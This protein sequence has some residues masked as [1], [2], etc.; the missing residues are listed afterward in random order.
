MQRRSRSAKP[1]KDGREQ[2]ELAHDAIL[3]GSVGKIQIR[4]RWQDSLWIDTLERKDDVFRL[5]R[6]VHVAS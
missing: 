4:Y 6:I 3:D 2:L 1:V 5:V